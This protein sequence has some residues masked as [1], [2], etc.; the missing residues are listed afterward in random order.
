[1]ARRKPPTTQAA[2]SLTHPNAASIDIGCADQGQDYFEER[3]R[4][5]LLH[6]LAQKA[7]AKQLVSA[8]N[9]A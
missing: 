9:P 8:V 1:M 4:Q 6:S 2:I 5:R 7:K 3:H